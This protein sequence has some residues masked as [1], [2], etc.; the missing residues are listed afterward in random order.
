[1]QGRSAEAV[2]RCREAIAEAER[3][4]ERRALAHAYH[5]MDYAYVELGQPQAAVFSPLALAIYKEL[6]D[7]ASQAVVQNDMGGF[8]YYQG[9]WNQAVDLYEEAARSWAAVGDPVRRAAAV[10]NI[11]EI[12]CDQLRLAEAL[13]LL[14]EAL[15]VWRAAGWRACVAL[16]TRLQGVVALR[17]GRPA[18]AMPLFEQ[19]REGF[20]ELGAQNEVTAT[21]GRIIECLLAE[22]RAESALA[23]A[24]GAVERATAAGAS[25]VHLPMLRR[26]QG[27]ALLQ[28][29]D[30]EGARAALEESLRA[31]RAQQAAYEVAL[32]LGELVRL[33]KI[34]GG[35]APSGLE[36]ER[37]AIL[38]GLG[39]ALPPQAAAEPEPS[40]V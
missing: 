11:A 5:I 40:G 28:A 25:N 36:A 2:R 29:G 13:T 18:E 34:E 37:D 22:G 31:A 14:D 39:V 38:A 16:G 19:A 17:A 15:R 9:R 35:V 32:T 30:V 26:V 10:F 24:R 23:L 8:A 21:D 12:R 4:G 1:M 33:A 20:A 6:D 27:A 7:L 3:A